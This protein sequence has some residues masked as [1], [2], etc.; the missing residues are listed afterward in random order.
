M[1]TNT[2]QRYTVEPVSVG[3]GGVTQRPAVWD[4]QTQRTVKVYRATEQATAERHAAGLNAQ[5]EADQERRDCYEASE[6]SEV[7]EGGGD[8]ELDSEREAY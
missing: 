4:R 3:D 8:L 6:Y 5:A 1:G 7:H 2:E